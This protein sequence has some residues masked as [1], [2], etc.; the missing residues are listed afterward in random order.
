M[1]MLGM[2]KNILNKERYAYD[3]FM[4]LSKAFERINHHLMIALLVEYGFPRDILPYMG[5]FFVGRLQRVCGR[6][7]YRKSIQL[8][9]GTIAIQHLH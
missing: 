2:W 8:N 4:D 3:T 1:Y 7:N 5:S 6:H 9:I